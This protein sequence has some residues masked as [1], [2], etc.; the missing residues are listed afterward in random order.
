MGLAV[1]IHITYETL[2]DLLRKE[3]SLEELQALDIRF[4][5]YVIEYLKDREA[6]Y[7]KTS[8]IEQEKTR[9]QLNNIKRIIKEIYEHRERKIVGL[10]VN[11]VRSDHAQF[12][13]TKNMLGEEKALYD[14][15]IQLL[16]RYK[17][18]VLTQVFN[19]TLPVISPQSYVVQEKSEDSAAEEDDQDSSQ[20]EGSV[21]ADEKS[22]TFISNVP[23]FLGKQG[24][25]YGPF[26]EG[27]TATLPSLI[28]NILLRKGKVQEA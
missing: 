15:T 6:F 9:I 3:R 19:K 25:V 18:E 7:E 28:A 10:A 24:E 2:F 21:A 26:Q 22:V 16:R 1:D 8:T 20:E 17:R 4:W 12:V 23:K 13:D 11:V 5:Q 14:E 27:E